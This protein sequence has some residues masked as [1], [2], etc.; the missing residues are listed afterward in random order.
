MLLDVP[1]DLLLKG[2][3]ALHGECSEQLAAPF[4]SHAMK[5]KNKKVKWHFMDAFSM[6]T[7]NFFFEF[8]LSESPNYEFCFSLNGSSR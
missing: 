6:V 8:D 2:K 4:D 7:Y 5:H 1:M 3:C